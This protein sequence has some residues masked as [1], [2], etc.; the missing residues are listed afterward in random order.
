MADDKRFYFNS[1][2][3]CAHGNPRANEILQRQREAEMEE[4]QA[5]EKAFF[6]P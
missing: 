3:S 5:Q 1:Q 6:V 2:Q 4:E